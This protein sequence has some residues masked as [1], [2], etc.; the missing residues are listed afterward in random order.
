MNIKV[1]FAI[2]ILIIVVGSLMCAYTVDETEQVLV[3]RFNKINRVVAEPGLHFKLPVIEKK[4]SYLKNLQEWDGDP[5]QIPTKEK[6]YISVDSF[7]RWRI[8]SPVL[9]FKTIGPVQD[10]ARYRLDEIIDP[11]VRDLITSNR[12]IDAVRNSNRKLDTFESDLAQAK[13]ETKKDQ[14]STYT[15]TTGRSEINLRIL[16]EAKPKLK[17]FGIELVDVKIKRINYVRD[18][19]DSVYGRMIQERKQ[20][21][22]KYRSEGQG[23]SR[24]ILGDKELEL[25]RIQ[26]RAYRKAQEIKGKADAEATRLYAETFGKD[27]GFYSFTKSLEIYN[28]AFNK[29]STLVLSTDSELL[30]YLKGGGLSAKPRK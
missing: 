9:F 19:R 4:I 23:E 22:E 15:V 6:R 12:L 28:E 25:K 18:V 8:T 1:I 24:K 2:L 16:A 11:A 7:A 27:P 30:K 21:A 5:G 26:S 29:S 10:N 3:T 13:V 17:K 14:L 20:I